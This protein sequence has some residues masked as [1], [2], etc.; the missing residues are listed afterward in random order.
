MFRPSSAL[1]CAVLAVSGVDAAA[2]DVDA[3]LRSAGF[4][5][6]VELRTPPAEVTRGLEHRVLMFVHFTCP[7]CRTFDEPMRTWGAGLPAPFK[8]EIV[9]AVALPEHAPMGLAYYAVFDIDRT[10]LP[11]F[12]RQLYSLLQ[13]LG[14][15]PTRLDTFVEAAAA[16]GISKEQFL[17]A[18]RSP[19]VL[20]YARRAEALTRAYGMN[21]VPTVVVGNR[22]MTNPRRVQNQS[23]SFITVMNG[24]VSMVIQSSGGRGQ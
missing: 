20:A 9:P 16:V 21:E 15:S 10:K 14:R 22:F 6:Y 3:A 23:E 17:A 4:E 12:E 2:G 1:L 11:G 24:L 5:P 18:A 13:D 7:F 19:R 8:F